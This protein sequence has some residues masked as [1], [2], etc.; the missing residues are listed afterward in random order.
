MKHS[1]RDY[2]YTHNVQLGA[3]YKAGSQSTDA[4]AA[5]MKACAD[6]VNASPDEVGK[7][8]VPRSRSRPTTFK[9]HS[10]TF[11][12]I[13]PSTTQLFRNL[14]ISL[15]PYIQSLGPSAEII[16]STV[17]HE[18]NIASWVFLAKTL[19]IKLKFWSPTDS[20]RNPHLT[21]ESLKPLL[22]KH[23][24]L[25][26]C[27]HTSNILGTITDVRAIADTVHTIPGAM[28]CVDG[29]A[30]APHRELDMKA[31]GVDFYSF[32]WYKVYGPHIAQLYASRTAQDR[33]MTTLGHYFKG[34]SSLEEKLGLA[35][36][37]YEL[38]QAIPRVV[39]YVRSIGW[40]AIVKH[41]VNISEVLLKYLRS[42]PQIEIIGE[43][44]SE[45]DKRV[46]VISFT[47]K[48]RTAQS[49]VENVEGKSEFGFRWGHFYS[50]RLVDEVLGL[51]GDG[52]VR[53]SMVHYNTIEE[54]ELLVKKIDEE[55]SKEGDG[56]TEVGEENVVAS[57]GDA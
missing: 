20:A 18:A 26:T 35:A 24:A 51:K 31:L 1:I 57:G 30:F 56:K 21:P 54:I 15:L 16:C 43:P 41:E 40:E 14:S 37:S 11:Q 10:N 32:S 19:S 36:A 6:Y 46:P 28:L 52:V 33:A 47:V 9:P 7:L 25:V 39:K 23:T 22:S 45:A 13:G 8:V 53:V 38:L 27:T 55:I 42:Q 17:D 34:S 3:T 4:Y 12:V 50:K 29:V 2:L 48:N 49:V 44:G 5:G